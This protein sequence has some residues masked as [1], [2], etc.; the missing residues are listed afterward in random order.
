V[1]NPIKYI[2]RSDL[3][4]GAEDIKK[5]IWYITK[6]IELRK[7]GS[8]NK[9]LDPQRVADHMPAAIGRAFLH[10]WNAHLR[11]GTEDLYKA[12]EILERLL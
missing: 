5:A 4:N 8:P 2:W 7:E 1:G 11:P 3:K 6:E 10:L 12:I 9:V